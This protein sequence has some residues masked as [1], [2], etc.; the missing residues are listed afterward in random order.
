MAAPLQLADGARLAYYEAGDRGAPAVVFLHAFPL[1]RAMWA[2]QCEAVARTHRAI[3]LDLRGFG[4]S[5]PGTERLT[6]DRAADDVVALLDHLGIARATIVGLSMGGY[7]AFAL[8]RRHRARVGALVLADT[9]AA[10]DTEDGRVKRAE[11]IALAR[12]EGSGAIADKQVVGLLGA[13][14][15]AENTALVERVRATIAQTPVEAIIAGAEALRDRP[16]A[17][18][19]LATIDVP[20]LLLCGEE[21]AVTRASEMRTVAAAIPAAQLEILPRAGHLSNLEQ[22]GTFNAALVAFLATN[23]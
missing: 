7:V 1:H 22:P 2:S 3:A 13:T 23:A 11:L 9:R 4:E 10:A 12:A 6:M 21:D 5:A 19:Q 17:T 8:Q 14:T 16:D 18:P 15:R 20:T